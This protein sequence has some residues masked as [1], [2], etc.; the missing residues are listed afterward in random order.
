MNCLWFIWAFPIF[1]YGLFPIFLFQLQEKHIPF[2]N[3]F[4]FRLLGM[5]V[6]SLP[7][8]GYNQICGLTRK[9]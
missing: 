8:L 1:P 7:I 9:Y 3:C 2:M 6:I 4:I 5:F